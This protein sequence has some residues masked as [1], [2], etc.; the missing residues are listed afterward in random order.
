MIEGNRDSNEIIAIAITDKNDFG[1][2]EEG[3]GGGE[4]KE[5][6]LSF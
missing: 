2:C 1:E 4:R 5:F 6:E 3:R